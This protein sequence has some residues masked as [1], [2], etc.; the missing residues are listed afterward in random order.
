M[1]MKLITQLSPSQPPR[2]GEGNTSHSFEMSSSYACFFS[3]HSFICLLYVILSFKNVME[4]QVLRS[5][6]Q[7]LNYPKYINKNP[8]FK[9]ITL[10][11][12]MWDKWNFQPNG[13]W[14]IKLFVVTQWNS[15]IIIKQCVTSESNFSF[16]RE[17]PRSQFSQ[18][19]LSDSVVVGMEVKCCLAPGCHKYIPEYT[20]PTFARSQHN[21]GIGLLFAL[22]S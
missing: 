5:N 21:F 19:V 11:F 12:Q 22:L 8:C 6:G 3:S 16:K 10:L 18:E 15:L 7:K 17:S 9:K 14:G 20:L 2:E 4:W 1:L 13:F